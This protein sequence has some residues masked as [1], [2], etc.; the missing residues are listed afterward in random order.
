MENENKK[1]YSEVI[2]IL[3]TIDSEKRLEELP[4]EMLEVLKAK[5][6][7]EYKPKISTEIPLDEQ[8]LQPETLSILSWIAMKY[9]KNELN[10]EENDI[11]KVEN[12]DRTQDNINK[13]KD[14][15]EE[16]KKQENVEPIENT[17]KE[18]KEQE[19][20]EK[21][22]LNEYNDSKLPILYEN[23]KWYQK[24]KIKIIEF[25]RKFFGKNKESKSIT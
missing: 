15:F 2:E 1:A 6:D 5:A 21:I 25:F 12:I 16:N 7:P 9:W 20:V 19:N 3:K 10:N 11:I 17:I 24:L 14:V 4:L 23:Y 18:D 22:N 13:I 8:N